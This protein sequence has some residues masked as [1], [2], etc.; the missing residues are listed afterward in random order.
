ML[1]ATVFNMAIKIFNLFSFSFDYVYIQCYLNEHE[2][3]LVVVYISTTDD[4]W[5]LNSIKKTS[6]ANPVKTLRLRSNRA[7]R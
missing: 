5:I 6:S 2:R 7:E 4:E 1:P 3:Q